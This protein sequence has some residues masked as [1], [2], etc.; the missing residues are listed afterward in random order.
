L[1]PFI[2]HPLASDPDHL[3]MHASGSF[4]GSGTMNGTVIMPL[5][6]NK[7]YHIKGVIEN[8]E[9][10]KLNLASENLGKIRIK[11]GFIDLLS[12]DFEMN[13]ER[14]IGKIIGAYHHLI[15]QQLEKHTDKKNV[16]RFSSFML[17]HLVIPLNK[18]K[19]LPEKKRTGKVNYV[20]DPTRFVAHY[21]LQ[22]LLMGIKKSFALGFLLPK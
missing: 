15:L 2:N 22:S 20:R 12:F 4:M 18:D 13:D 19:S 16:A 21:F 7:P 17:T 11:S 5:Q 14:S 8:L 9:L 1:S 6:A 10:T 3:T